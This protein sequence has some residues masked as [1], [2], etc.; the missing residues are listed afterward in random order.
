MFVLGFL[1]VAVAYLSASFSPRQPQTV[2]L[3]IGYSGLRFALTLLA[4][5][6]VQDLVG[7]EIDRRTT[8][9]ALTYPVPRAAYLLGRYLGIVSLALL[10]TLA[11]G[12]ALWLAVMLAGGGYDQGFPPILGLPF[13]AALAGLWLQVAVVTAFALCIASVSTVSILP[14]AIGAAFAIAG[15][16]IG[17]VREY[18]LSGADRDTALV[19]RF[20]PLTSAIQWVVPD[21]SRLDWR[22]WPM[23][24]VAPE[25]TVAGLAIALALTYIVILL[26][27]AVSAF[28]RREFD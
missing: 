21:L 13:W 6:W 12:L 25:G 10:A 26:G 7:K 15:S 1:L 23:Y 14:L 17:A 22:A 16:S 5:F 28:A 11:L 2:A 4:L 3:D 20:D 8:M 24:S 9:F 18:L 27:I 19:A